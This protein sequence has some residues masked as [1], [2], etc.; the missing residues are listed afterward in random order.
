MAF[1]TEESK[2]IREEIVDTVS[3]DIFENW[4]PTSLNNFILQIKNLLNEIEIFQRKWENRIQIRKNQLLAMNKEIS[5]ETSIA[6]AALVQQQKDNDTFYYETLKIISKVEIYLDKVRNFFVTDKNSISFTFGFVFGG[7]LH[8]YELTLED[9]LKQARVGIDSNTKNLKLFMSRSKKQLLEAFNETKKNLNESSI[10]FSSL[11]EYYNSHTAVITNKNGKKIKTQGV[12]G[13]GKNKR[14]MNMGQLYELYRYLVEVKNWSQDKKFDSKN[15]KDVAEF[16]SAQKR[17][18]NNIS[19]RK[20][21]DI[22]NSQVKFH[23]ASFGSISTAYRDLNKLIKILLNLQKNKDIKQFKNEI[24]NLFTKKG[25]K[26][27]TKIEKESIKIAEEKLDK[28]IK[29]S[30]LS[31]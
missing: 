31:K 22:N 28:I 14:K 29:E 30:F 25:E 19:G 11:I 10:L 23:N 20:G 6:W 24:L 4:P 27:L 9:M 8:E 21:G 18:M 15:K 12:F 1:S 17:S 7:E 3:K 16:Y 13:K 2:K 26:T 5:S